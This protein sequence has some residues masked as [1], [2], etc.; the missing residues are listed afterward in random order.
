MSRRRIQRVV[1][2]M[3]EPMKDDGSLEVLIEQDHRCHYLSITH[4]EIT[5]PTHKPG[6]HTLGIDLTPEK[7]RAIASGLLAWAA[8]ASGEPRKDP[9][10]RIAIA[11]EQVAIHMGERARTEVVMITDLE[12]I[13]IRGYG[14]AIREAGW[15]TCRAEELEQRTVHE[16]DLRLALN[17]IARDCRE[18]VAA[19]ESRARYW[20]EKLGMRPVEEISDVATPATNDSGV[21]AEE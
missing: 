5:S 4:H 11:L 17:E 3:T 14:D 12:A 20:L 8:E 16:H 19:A 10:T 13:A 15:W 7:A 1:T 6:V 9:L 21:A 18:R 2:L